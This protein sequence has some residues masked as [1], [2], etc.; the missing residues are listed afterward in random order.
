MVWID[1]HS[2]R[3]ISSH[4]FR[5]LTIDIAHPIPK[6][7]PEDWAELDKGVFALVKLPLGMICWKSWFIILQL[8]VG[9][10]FPRLRP[11]C[12]P[13]FPRQMPAC[14]FEQSAFPLLSSTENPYN[15][16]EGRLFELNQ[17]EDIFVYLLFQIPYSDSLFQAAVPFTL[18]SSDELHLTFPLHPVLPY[19]PPS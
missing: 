1:H 4:Q 8:L 11:G 16:V 10:S 18:G 14:C 3:A 15:Y 13:L 19:L 6:T 7:N 2:P 9:P 5:K 12:Y 17:R